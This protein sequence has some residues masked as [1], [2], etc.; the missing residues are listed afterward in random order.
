MKLNAD[1]KNRLEAMKKAL[2]AGLP[3]AGLL[4]GTVLAVSASEAAA[5]PG[6]MLG[7][8]LPL[9]MRR[10]EPPLEKPMEKLAEPSAS[11]EGDTNETDNSIR[12]AVL[13]DNPGP[14][15]LPPPPPS[16]LP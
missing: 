2:A 1:G 16:A 6:Q 9:D 8:P 11:V 3:L 14:D 15:D 4:A 7:A 5:V 12:W 13:G 10:V